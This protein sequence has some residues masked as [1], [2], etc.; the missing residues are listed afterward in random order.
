MDDV[1]VQ[2]LSAKHQV[3]DDAGVVGDFH[4]HGILDG[5]HGGQVVDVGA[6][7]AQTLGD[8]GASRGSRP[9]RMVS[10]PRNKVAVDQALETR[11]LS[12][13]TSIRR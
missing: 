13:S 10:T 9:V 7:P 12:T 1:I 3:A 5:T 4:P 8:Q 6:H 11:P 2:E